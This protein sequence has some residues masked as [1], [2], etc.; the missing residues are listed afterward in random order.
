ME[1]ETSFDYHSLDDLQDKSLAE[2]EALWDLVPTEDR[3]RLQDRYK[4]KLKDAGIADDESEIKLIEYYLERYRYEGLVPAGK[5]WI[6]LGVERRQAFASESTAVSDNDGAEGGIPRG[7]Q[8]MIAFVVLLLIIAFISNIMGGG[9]SEEELLGTATPTPTSTA[10]PTATATTTATPLPTATALA[11]I[12]SD[13]FIEDGAGTRRDVYPVQLQVLIADETQPRIFIIQERLIETTEW[14]FDFNPDVASWLS[15]TR[16][17]PVFGIP[18]DS[19]NLDLFNRLGRGTRFTIRMNTGS[20]LVF[21][22]LETRSIGR[23]DTAPLQQTSPG[24][25]LALIGE[26]DAE[27]LP[28][29]QRQIVIGNY[30]LSDINTLSVIPDLPIAMDSIY[31]AGEWQV[32][33][34]DLNRTPLDNPAFTRLEIDLAWTS[35]DLINLASYQ[36]VLEGAETNYVPDLQNSLLLTQL[37]SDA[38]GDLRLSFIVPATLNDGRLRLSGLDTEQLFL[39]EMPVITETV[40]ISS[41]DLQIRNTWRDDQAIHFDIRLF[42]PSDEALVINSTD[43]HMIFGLSPAPL[44]SRVYPQIEQA[45]TLAGQASFD[46]TIS[47]A[48][49]T[50]DPYASFHFGDYRFDLTLFET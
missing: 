29:S 6:K 16:I 32:Q 31:D 3:E 33:V 37:P 21:D 26:L 17:R 20:E 34:S 24:I 4:A 44:G 28:T 10:T 5:Q 47:F 9:T 25:V 40:S 30:N 15:G 14:N 42:N 19:S 18:F 12:E 45:H 11:L 22:Y 27:G 7:I 50:S 41:L 49:N 23:F 2:L 35:Q 38:E 46:L 48:W 13:G 39:L 8:F 36:W 1:N 43:F